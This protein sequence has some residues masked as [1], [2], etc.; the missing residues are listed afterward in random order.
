[1]KNNNRQIANVSAKYSIGIWIIFVLLYALQ[2]F[3]LPDEDDFP[4]YGYLILSFI[5]LEIICFDSLILLIHLCFWKKLSNY[6]RVFIIISLLIII[7]FFLYTG[8]M[9][10][11]LTLIGP[12]FSIS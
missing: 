3:F 1:M 10:F 4:Y 2:L 9:P 7:I 12:I 6:S 5:T 11:M 8:L